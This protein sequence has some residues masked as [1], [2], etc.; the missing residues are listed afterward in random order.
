MESGRH[1]PIVTVVIPT[2]SGER[3]E[4][5]C[6]H[7]ASVQRPPIV[8]QAMGA[9]KEFNFAAVC[10]IALEVEDTDVVIMG[11]DVRLQTP[12]GLHRLQQVAHEWDGITSAAIYGHGPPWQGQTGRMETRIVPRTL[13]FHCVMIPRFVIEKVGTMDERFTGYGMEDNDYCLRARNAGFNLVVTDECH[14]NHGVDIS[15]SWRSRK[16]YEE[17]A[18]YNRRVFRDKWAK[19]PEEV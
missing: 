11:D 18:L 8:I 7:L 14:V 4:S 9:D 10:N 3:A 17:Q 13:A 15:S 1:I 19:E 6:R 12:N 2:L 16:D 5:A